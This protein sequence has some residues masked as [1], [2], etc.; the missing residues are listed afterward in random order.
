M[1]QRTLISYILLVFSDFFYASILKNFNS[2]IV[3]GND[4]NPK[5]RWNVPS[6]PCQVIGGFVQREL[7]GSVI[8]GAGFMRWRLLL[9]LPGGRV[10]TEMH[11]CPFL[12][13]EW[14]GGIRV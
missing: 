13:R 10:F 8:Y 9:R 2:F 1:S 7:V 3:L 5:L 4:V 14:R 6:L 11:V 12:S